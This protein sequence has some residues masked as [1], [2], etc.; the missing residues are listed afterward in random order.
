MTAIADPPPW[1]EPDP[2]PDDG[3]DD[4]RRAES[5]PDDRLPD[6]EAVLPDD[7]AVQGDS[8]WAVPGLGTGDDG[9]GGVGADDDGAGG[10]SRSSIAALGE[11]AAAWTALR[12]A[13]AR[14]YRALTGLHESDAVAESGYRSTSRLLT[15]H[16]R[17]DPREATRLQGHA[18]SLAMRVS[19][20]G[21]RDS[22]ELPAT[23]AMVED[24]VIGPGHVEV[25]RRTMRR[26]AAVRGLDADTLTTTEAQLAEL[27]T[28][29]SPA[30]LAEA[31]TAILALLDPDGTAPDD[32]PPPENELHYLRRRDGS[33]VG[34]FTYRD[35]AAAETLNTALTS[36]TPPDETTVLVDDP[37]PESG[38]QTRGADPGAHALRTLPARRAQAMLDLASEALTRGLDLDDPAA[39][40]TGDGL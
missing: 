31:A 6:D 34:K 20:S 36:A 32:D 24:G 26:L 15:D 21:R 38:E 7:D 10:L 37:A 17:I 12:G 30:A 39:R 23:A 25:I 19:P 18:R 2:D 27:A 4:P 9:R 40:R 33:L 11:A 16:L 3:P 5:S 8:G 35:P 28:T 22:A 14:C 13:Q 1:R 29:H